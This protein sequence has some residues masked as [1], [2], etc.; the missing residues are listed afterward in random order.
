MPGI[1]PQIRYVVVVML[2]N[3]SFDDLCGWLYRDTPPPAQFLP[4]S[5]SSTPF[6]GLHAGLFNPLQES[7]FTDQSGGTYP[8]FP[9][10]NAT[11]MP[12]PDPEEDYPN[13]N[14][15]L[16][17]PEAPTQNPSWPNLGFVINYAKVTGTNIPVQ[18]MQPFS[19]IRYRFFPH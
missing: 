4:A 1:L 10:S 9:Q 14:Q 13:V 7:Y 19:A 15:Q 8:I 6:N 12:N 18:I 2:E 3:R 16:F 17:G 11:I 5:S